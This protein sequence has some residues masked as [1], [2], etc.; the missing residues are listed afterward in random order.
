[1]VLL[2]RDIFDRFDYRTFGEIEQIIKRYVPFYNNDRIHGLL[3]KMT[4]NE[5]WQKD[6]HLTTKRQAVA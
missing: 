4:P 1:M 3:G 2:K 6:I 5:K